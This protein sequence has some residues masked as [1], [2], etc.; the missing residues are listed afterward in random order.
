MSTDTKTR[1]YDHL[2]DPWETRTSRLPARWN[3]AAAESGERP[4]VLTGVSDWL[5]LGV[6]IDWLCDLLLVIAATP[7]LDW[8]LGT[9]RPELWKQ[10]MQAVTVFYVASGSR[11]AAERLLPAHKLASAWLSGTPPANVRIGSQ[12]ST[13]REFDV[14]AANIRAI[15]ACGRFFVFEALLEPIH[16]RPSIWPVCM[17]WPAQYASPA[18]A[19]ADG[20]KVTLSRQRLI[21]AERASGLIDT[22]IVTGYGVTHSHNWI[23]ELKTQ[24]AESGTPIYIEADSRSNL[25][26]SVGPKN[27]FATLRP[28]TP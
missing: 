10:R 20:A 14:L 28:L 24:C 11:A 5:G 8:F 9:S 26:D 1:W 27:A 12:G 13:Q 21:S 2:L 22:V 23:C 18:A 7:N 19:R 6:R 25:V 16:I 17:S 3:E 4:R 15:P